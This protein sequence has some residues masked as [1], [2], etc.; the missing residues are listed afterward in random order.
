MSLVVDK[1]AHGASTSTIRLGDQLNSTSQ[2]VSKGCNFTLGF[3]TIDD[4]NYSYIGIWYTNDDHATRA[5]V[6]N[7]NAPLVTDTVVLTIDNTTGKLVIA[8]EGKIIFNVSNQGMTRGTSATLEDSR[9][10]VLRDKV[11]NQILWQSFD[12]PNNALL[13]GMKLGYNVTS[14]QNWSLISW[15]SDQ[16][17]VNGAFILSWDLKQK[18]LVVRRRGELYW[19]SGIFE[20]QKLIVNLDWLEYHYDLITV[21]N[22]E[23]KYFA[24][25]GINGPFPMW[26]LTPEGRILDRDNSLYLCI[27]EFCYGYQLDNGCAETGF[28]PCRRI[29]DKFELKNGDFLPAQTTSSFDDNSSIGLSDCMES[30]WNNCNCVGFITSNGTGCIIWMGSNEFRIN[31]QGSS[32]SK[33]LFV[34]KISSKVFEIPLR[35][36]KDHPNS[37]FEEEVMIK[38]PAVVN[39]SGHQYPS[40]D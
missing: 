14:G 26:F 37:S 38:I 7:P 21:D 39:I 11:E 29:N 27:P 4:T 30:C 25:G 6:A 18:Q 9:N 19:S 3:F 33:Y 2:L 34:P 22:A 35:G 23:E 17:P 10:F 32:V 1:M 16:I 12:H 13:P 24:I 15:L 20:S 31:E 40:V 28:P 5:W 8:T 36:H